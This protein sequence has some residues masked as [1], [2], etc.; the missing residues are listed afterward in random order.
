MRKCDRELSEVL[1]ITAAIDACNNDQKC[2]YL[3]TNNVNCKGDFKLCKGTDLQT[4]SRG[5]CTLQ[6]G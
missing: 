2:S 1:N 3:S 5:G 4:S 6:K